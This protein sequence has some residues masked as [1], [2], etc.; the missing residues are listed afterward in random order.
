MRA[1]KGKKPTTVVNASTKIMPKK[2][3]AKIE[4]L[5]CPCGAKPRWIPCGDIDGYY[6]H[7]VRSHAIWGPQSKSRVLAAAA[8]NEMIRKWREKA[9]GK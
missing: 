2:T 9:R 1:K 3:K 8:W 5:P 4:T 6:A 7:D